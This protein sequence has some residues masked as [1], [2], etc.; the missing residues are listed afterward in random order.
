MFRRLETPNTPLAFFAGGNPNGATLVLGHA[1]GVNHHMWDFVAEI[2]G[3]NYRLV[4]WDQPGHGESELLPQG[5][6]A[7]MN[8]LVAALLSGIKDLALDNYHLGGL[9][10]GGMTSLAAA[11]TQSSGISSLG[12]FD[13]TPKLAPAKQWLKKAAQV[14]TNGVESLMDATLQRWLTEEF[15]TNLGIVQTQKI[16]DLFLSTSNAGYA[17]CCRIIASADLWPG[18][19]KVEVPTLL[20]TG[21]NDAGA[22]PAVLREMEESLS[23]ALVNVVPT[24]M[25]LSAVEKPVE[26]AAAISAFVMQ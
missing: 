8:H 23:D 3:K 7:T 25:H 26:V 5:N 14:E 17:Q 21:E 19:G 2:L 22:T 10:L 18:M 16:R 13:A 15:R 12:V 24:A 6:E 20:L 4:F 11:Q 1:L 9:S